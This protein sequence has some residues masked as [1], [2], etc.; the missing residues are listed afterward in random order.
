VIFELVVKLPRLVRNVKLA[1][2]EDVD[3]D[4]AVGFEAHNS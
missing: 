4:E 2:R 3:E 1:F